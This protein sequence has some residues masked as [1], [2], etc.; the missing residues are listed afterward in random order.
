MCKGNALWQG[1]GFMDTSG[2]RT[3][4]W[5]R[6]CVLAGVGFM[7]TSG[8]RDHQLVSRRTLKPCIDYISRQVSPKVNSTNAANVLVSVTSLLVVLIDLNALSWV[9]GDRLH[10]KFQWSGTWVLDPHG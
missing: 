8:N 1:V 7:D 4:S 2:N 10:R 9:G 6:E 5:D 3:T